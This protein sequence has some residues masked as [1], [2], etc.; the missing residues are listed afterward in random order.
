MS[1]EDAELE[2][3]I[4]QIT[5][6]VQ[7]SKEKVKNKVHQVVESARSDINDMLKKKRREI[8]S[9]AQK[10]IADSKKWVDLEE[11]RLQDL[12]EQ[13]VGL[14]KQAQADLKKA[15]DEKESL[16]E[17]WMEA[18]RKYKRKLAE[19]EEE[20]Q[21]EWQDFQENSHQL[22][23]ETTA[24]ARTLLADKSKGNLQHLLGMLQRELGEED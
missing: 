19:M 17:Q 13:C 1:L 16:Q 3:Y 15:E 18:N 8:A 24:K 14:M 6:A 10:D 12:H 11:Q 5:R 20:H 4:G 21:A 2:Q 23:E 22:L 7:S 9:A